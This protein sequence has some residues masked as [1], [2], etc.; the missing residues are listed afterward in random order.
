MSDTITSPANQAVKELASLKEKK[1]RRLH[2]LYLAEGEKMVKEALAAGKT[3]RTVAAVSAYAGKF[4]CE[5][6][7]VVSESVFGKITGEVNPQGVLAAIEIPENKPFFPEGNCLLLDGISDPGN[8]GTIVRTAAAAGIREIF[9]VNCADFYSPKAVRSSMSGIYFVRIFCGGYDEIFPLLEG[10]ELIAAD[11]GGEDVFRYK[12]RGR[13]CLAVG[14]EAN[15]LSA[16]VKARADKT[17]GVPMEPHT[18]SLNAAVSCA[19]MMYA[20]SRVN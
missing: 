6:E 1:Y 15:G 3:L 17:L 10:A 14:N 4:A 2:G 16:E 13:F 11:M 5:R 9:A 12:P 18:E 7:L 20:L 19:V 8:V